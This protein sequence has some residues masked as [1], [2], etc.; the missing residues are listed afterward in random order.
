VQKKDDKHLLR[1][2]AIVLAGAAL[3]LMFAALAQGT[4]HASPI[5]P[6]IKRMLAQPQTEPVKFEPARAGW[7]G[8][9]MT[10]ATLPAALSSA[11]R[12]RAIHRT[13]ALVM[14]P[15]PRAVFAILAAIVVLRKL[16]SMRERRS[17][18]EAG[19]KIDPQ[20]GEWQMPQAA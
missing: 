9:E 11:A 1:R 16:R 5:P 19:P 4:A 3:F 2:I 15:D 18:R 7:N 12:V 10:P 8:P 6:D 13:L 17:E 20:D 14:T